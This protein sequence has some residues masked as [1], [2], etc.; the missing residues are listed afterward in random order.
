MGFGLDGFFVCDRTGG[1]GGIVP[2]RLCDNWK[3]ASR[4]CAGQIGLDKADHLI[5]AL[6]SGASAHDNG[7][8]VAAVQFG[9]GQKIKA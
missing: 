2:I 3:G 8:D 4:G 5:I 6:G 7:D 1:E 9:G